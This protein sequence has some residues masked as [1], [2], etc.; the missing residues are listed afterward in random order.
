[1]KATIRPVSRDRIEVSVEGYEPTL[2]GGHAEIEAAPTQSGALV[3]VDTEDDGMHVLY[4]GEK[5]VDAPLVT[6]IAQRNGLEVKP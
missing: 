4:V 3:W 5:P 1:M 6:Y 2:V